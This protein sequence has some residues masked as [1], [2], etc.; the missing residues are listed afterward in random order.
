MRKNNAVLTQYALSII[1]VLAF[2][3]RLGASILSRG[4]GATLK[5]DEHVFTRIAWNLVLGNSYSMN[6]KAPTAER[7]PVYPLM[8]A[9][10]FRLSSANGLA[11]SDKAGGAKQYGVW[12]TITQTRASNYRVMARVLNAIMGTLTVLLVYLIGRRLFNV[13]VALVASLIVALNRVFIRYSMYIVSDTLFC[14]MVSLIIYVFIKIQER[15]DSLL[16]RLLGGVLVGIGILTRS[17]LFLFV[18]FLFIWSLILHRTFG[19]AVVTLVIILLP[20]LLLITPWIVRNY[21]VFGELVMATN[22]GYTFWGIHNPETFS[23][24]TLMGKWDPPDDTVRNAGQNPAGQNPAGQ[25]PAHR[26]LSE[27]EWNRYLL[28]QGLQTIRKNLS[29]MPRLELYKLC[30]LILSDGAIRQLLRFPWLYLFVFGLIFMLTSGNHRP[31]LIL[32]VLIAYSILTTLVFYTCERLRMYID[33]VFYTIASYG[34]SEFL[35]LT[36]RRLAQT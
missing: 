8:L 28:Q 5:N 13:D 22:L 4:L 23:D 19:R 29:A 31:F 10:I 20:I 12:S 36:K 32:Y 35:G 26:Y 11:G 33:P 17:E 3:S 7:P 16:L 14:F 30:K 1:L 25:D 24:E 9:G 15:P 18:P 21:V 34:L 2:V 6:G 27:P